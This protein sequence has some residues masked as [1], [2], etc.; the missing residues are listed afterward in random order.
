[1]T[2]D[3]RLIYMAKDEAEIA[4]YAA[5][6][7]LA[8]DEPEIAAY[9]EA[10]QLWIEGLERFVFYADQAA[11]S[12]AKILSFVSESFFDDYRNSIERAS[13]FTEK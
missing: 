3:N 6:L 11:S 2:K 9:I 5:R 13:S 12:P 8:Y 10:G 4:A 7:N 1:M